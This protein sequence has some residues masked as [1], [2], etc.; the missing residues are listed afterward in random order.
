MKDYEEEKGRFFWKV[1][2]QMYFIDKDH[3]ILIIPLI[4]LNLT[5]ACTKIAKFVFEE[6]LPNIYLV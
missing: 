6:M 3:L 2:F 1:T 4:V 5:L